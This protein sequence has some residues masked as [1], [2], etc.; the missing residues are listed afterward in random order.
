MVVA[1]GGA[2]LQSVVRRREDDAALGICI[3]ELS[4]CCSFSLSRGIMYLEQP[5]RLAGTIN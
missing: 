1:R 4:R 2:R 3:L 5:H